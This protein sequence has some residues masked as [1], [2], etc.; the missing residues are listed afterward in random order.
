MIVRVYPASRRT[1]VGG[2]YGSSEPPVLVVRVAAPATDGKANDAVLASLAAAF[3]VPRR[4]AR[5]VSGARNR[6]KVVEVEGADSEQL[7]G[8]IAATGA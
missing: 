2:R 1:S 7:T 4:N 6:T 8:L 5:L 3:N